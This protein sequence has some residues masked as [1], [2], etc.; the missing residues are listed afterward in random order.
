M[1]KIGKILIVSLNLIFIWIMFRSTSP[2]QPPRLEKRYHICDVG[3]SSLWILAQAQPSS[4]QSKKF[5]FLK[6]TFIEFI[7]QNQFDRPLVVCKGF[8]SDYDLYRAKTLNAKIKINQSAEFNIGLAT[9]SLGPTW[10]RKIKHE[11]VDTPINMSWFLEGEELSKTSK[12]NWLSGNFYGS[13]FY[14]EKF[15]KNKDLIIT[16]YEIYLE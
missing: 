1:N 12:L 16:I 7:Y 10:S 6:E 5:P 11:E 14:V 8:I 4:V 13:G 15:D 3:N 2:I 9:I